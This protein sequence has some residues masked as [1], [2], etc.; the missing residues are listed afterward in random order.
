MYIYRKSKREKDCKAKENSK[1]KELIQ[2]GL[3]SGAERIGQNIR[4]A[5]RLEKQENKSE[6]QPTYGVNK[7]EAA[8]SV[9]ARN[10]YAI[11]KKKA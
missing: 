9:A 1:P 6:S 11:G 2:R 3:S 4:E 10:A 5:G 7:T 8:A